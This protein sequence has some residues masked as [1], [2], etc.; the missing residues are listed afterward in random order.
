[1]IEE[2]PRRAEVQLEDARATTRPRLL[3]I[4]LLHYLTNYIVSHV[5][6]FSVRRFWYGRLLGARFGEHAGIHLGCHLWF[7]TPGQLRRDGFRIGAYSRVNRNCCLDA[8]GPLDIGEHVSIPPEVMILTASH[9]VN[10]PEFRVEMRP[11]VI[12]D[13]VWIGSRALIL[14][15]VTLG[16]GCV[17]AAGSVVTR[18]VEPLSIVAGVPARPV[19]ERDECATHYVL[20]V[21]FPLFE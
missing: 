15:G 20:D 8:R 14:P 19:G 16:R 18:D 10:D 13:H 6:S 21:P 2:L 9:R 4:R 3:A 12:E 17:V 5:P 11:V 1:V 7:Y